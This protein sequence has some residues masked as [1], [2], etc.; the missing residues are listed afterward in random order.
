MTIEQSKRQ[1]SVIKQ[2]STKIGKYI[3][4]TDMA[5]IYSLS[6]RPGS[7]VANMLPFASNC[8]NHQPKYL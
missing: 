1:G 8:A 3:L 7:S 5:G 6:V 2:E 4:N